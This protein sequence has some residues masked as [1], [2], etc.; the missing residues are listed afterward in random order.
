MLKRYSDFK[1]DPKREDLTQR[2][3]DKIKW[4]KFKIV[5]PTEE[6]KNEIMEALKHFHDNQF[7]S[8]YITANQLAHEYL[9]GSSILVDK[10]LYEKIK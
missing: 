1:E 5:V 9:N 4:T 10:E 8:D 7:D 3:I 2:E 6:D